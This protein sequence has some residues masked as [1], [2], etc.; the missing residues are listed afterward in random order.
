[1][2]KHFLSNRERIT[3]YGHFISSYHL[4]TWMQQ[5]NQGDDSDLFSNY[6]LAVI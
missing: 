5:T 4:D 2:H 1:M 3:K 6:S